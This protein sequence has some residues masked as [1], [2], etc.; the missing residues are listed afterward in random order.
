MSLYLSQVQAAARTQEDVAQFHPSAD[1]RFSAQRALADVAD[2]VLEEWPAKQS[3]VKFWPYQWLKK[4][5]GSGLRIRWEQDLHRKKE[6]KPSAFRP[7]DRARWRFMQALDSLMLQR[8]GETVLELAGLTT[9]GMDLPD[10]QGGFKPSSW[11]AAE[12]KT[13]LKKF[14]SMVPGFIAGLQ[15]KTIN[16]WLD[17]EKPL[18]NCFE[19]YWNVVV[20]PLAITGN[21]S[22][23]M[24]WRDRELG[25][26]HNER[27]DWEVWAAWSKH[28]PT[29]KRMLLRHFRERN[30][31]VGDTTSMEVPYVTFVRSNSK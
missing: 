28:A 4:K 13:S 7:L 12:L 29:M 10:P 22:A 9:S 16:P 14:Y 15:D 17:I 19:L 18:V 21:P 20:E 6:T 8:R 26:L 23:W 31:S 11:S 24:Q 3:C 1:V 27:R 2:L 30:P 25:P 5:R